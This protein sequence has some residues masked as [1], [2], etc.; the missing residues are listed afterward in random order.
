V[1]YVV[2]MGNPVRA[3][4]GALTGLT[5]QGRLRPI[6]GILDLLRN[7]GDTFRADPS[8]RLAPGSP[9][10]RFDYIISDAGRFWR[11]DCVADDPAAQY[12]V[13]HLVWLDCQ[14]G[15]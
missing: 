13:L 4:L 3:Y 1:A 5:R 11:A 6:V 12:G 15:A 10:F 7:D 14:P 9:N 8:R 2:R